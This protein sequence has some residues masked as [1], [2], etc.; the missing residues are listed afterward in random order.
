MR[1]VDALHLKRERCSEGFVALPAFSWNGKAPGIAKGDSSGKR[2]LGKRIGSCG[3]P[4]NLTLHTTSQNCTVARSTACVRASREPTTGALGSRSTYQRTAR[5]I[6]R[7]VWI[8]AGY[9]FVRDPRILPLLDRPP[10][11]PFDLH[12]RGCRQ[13]RVGQQ[14]FCMN[15]TGSRQWAWWHGMHTSGRRFSRHAGQLCCVSLSHPPPSLS[16]DPLDGR[17]VL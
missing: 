4:L 7:E 17:W 3:E 8:M 15:N 2:A 13:V 10:K 6:E 1:D 14:R 12:A 5:V 11:E 16:T 9:P